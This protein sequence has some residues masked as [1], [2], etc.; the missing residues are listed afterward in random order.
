MVSGISSRVLLTSWP[1][2]GGTRVVV[3]SF[4]TV[5]ADV[6]LETP[7]VVMTSAMLDAIVVDGT[8]VTGF[9]GFVVVGL[10]LVAA[11]VAPMVDDNGLVFSVIVVV[12]LLV[13][14]GLVVLV[15]V[16]AIFVVVLAIFVVVPAGFNLVVVDDDGLDVVVLL[17]VVVLTVV[18]LIVVVLIVGAF[19]VVFE[20][21]FGVVVLVL[22]NF[23][24][25]LFVVVVI[26]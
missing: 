7:V 19:V 3:V 20:V 4:L 17:S 23:W 22:V 13:Y 18:A 26:L 8:F 15:V 14:S 5:K 11:I 6:E 1:F 9:V 25:A 10:G 2:V 16:L 12:A 21:V 24:S